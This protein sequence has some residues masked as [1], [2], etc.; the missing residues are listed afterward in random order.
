MI[1]FKTKINLGRN[2]T[3]RDPYH[4]EIIVEDVDLNNIDEIFAKPDS[5]K[6]IKQTKLFSIAKL[7]KTTYNKIVR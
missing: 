3:L 2:E 5:N 6:L 1:L 7:I 4:G